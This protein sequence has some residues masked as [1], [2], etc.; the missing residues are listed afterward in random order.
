VPPIEET[1]D[2]LFLH[3]QR[4]EQS[5]RTKTREV[6]KGKGGGVGKEKRKKKKRTGKRKRERK[7]RRSE[8]V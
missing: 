6:P 7:W 3:C 8:K 5:P 4:N 2:R 1:D